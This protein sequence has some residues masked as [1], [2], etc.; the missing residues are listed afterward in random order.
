M[1]KSNEMKR[2]FYFISFP[3]GSTL[4]STA[5]I[6]LQFTM[7]F[8]ALQHLCNCRLFLPRNRCAIVYAQ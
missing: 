1:D 5:K 3:S 4:R 6:C 7:Q 2:V 8:E